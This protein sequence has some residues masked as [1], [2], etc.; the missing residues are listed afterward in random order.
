MLKINNVA[1]QYGN[2]QA[3]K[4]VSLE[5]KQGEA[6]TLIGSNGAGKST[7]L[8]TISGL[9]RPKAGS[10]LFE[11]EEITN[12]N[13]DKIV[14]RGIAHVPEGRRIFTNM[15]VMENLR[16][17]AYLRKDKEQL[18]ADYEEVFSL[19]PI[20]KERVN[21]MAGTLSGGEQQMLAL[22][23]ALLS[24]PKLII[25][26]EPSLGLAP[27][28]VDIV[29]DVIKKVQKLGITVLLVEQNAH[30]ALEASE[31]AYVIETGEIKFSGISSSLLKDERVIEA[32][33][34]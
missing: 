7:L 14:S 26:D 31:R 25:L 9:I 11:G 4:G 30:L 20:L 2:V 24:K 29:F 16:I 22:S 8:K 3:L 21:Q 17:G 12:S 13:P 33:L 32:Y 10:I 19:F 18:K 6:V 23:R 1:V 28:M 15:T 5:V 27:V 34:G